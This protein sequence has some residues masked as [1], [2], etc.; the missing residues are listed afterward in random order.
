MTQV[1]EKEKIGGLKERR[2]YVVL[3]ALSVFLSLCAA[4]Y[5]AHVANSNEHKF[6]D[7][8]NATISVTVAPAD[9]VKDP[10]RYRAY[11][12]YLKFKKLDHDLGCH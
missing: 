12:Y 11:L 4:L 5:G 6:C 8:I 10:S 2:G 9:P 7:I 3:V 1:L